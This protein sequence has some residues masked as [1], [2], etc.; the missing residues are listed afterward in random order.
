MPPR[1]LAP[2][3][4]SAVVV[5]RGGMPESVHAIAAGVTDRAGLATTESSPGAASLETFVRSAAKPFQALAAVEHGA[6]DGLGLDERHLAVAC[7]S[8][9][10][11]SDAVRLVGE[12]LTAAGLDE[13]SLGCATMPP[14]DRHVGKELESRGEPVGPIHHNC[15]GKHALGLALCVHEGWT[16]DSYLDAGHPLQHALRESMARA[17]GADLTEGVDGCGMRAYRMPVAALAAAFGRLAGGGL[18]A[19]GERVAN[20]MAAAPRLIGLEGGIDVELM[21]AVP[22]LVAKLGAEGVIGVG[23]PDGR[24]LAVKVLDGSRRALGPAAVHA[25]REGLALAAA[26]EALDALAAPLVKTAGG[27]EA[28]SIVAELTLAPGGVKDSRL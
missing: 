11:S 12:I 5:T 1:K 28:G 15:S 7:A 19:A 23:L 9:D 10:S 8:H 17:A 4:S 26:S 14:L 18:G 3:A 24:G 16:T 13:S 20:A 2:E 25:V 22:G 6:L 21:L 27:V